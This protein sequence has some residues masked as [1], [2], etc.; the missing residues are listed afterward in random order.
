MNLTTTGPRRP[1]LSLPFGQNRP[2]PD[3]FG[4]GPP[5]LLPAH[6]LRRM[7]AAMID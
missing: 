6:E 7:V 5:P 3:A 2:G 4:A 1:K